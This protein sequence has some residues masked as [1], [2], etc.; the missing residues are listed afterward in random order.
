MVRGCEVLTT[1]L[2]WVEL[3]PEEYQL[4]SEGCGQGERCRCG[5]CKGK[6]EGGK[7]ENKVQVVESVSTFC[8]GETS[9]FIF[10]SKTY[11]S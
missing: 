5:W 9:F 8:N 6:K 4:Y 10:N 3:A 11:C 7:Q 2:L 1:G